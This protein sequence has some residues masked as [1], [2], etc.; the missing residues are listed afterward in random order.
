MTQPNCGVCGAE[1]PPP[2]PGFSGRRRVTSDCKPYPAGGALAECASC[3][4]VQKPNDAA[5]RA[6][7]DAIYDAYDNYALTDGVEQSV[8]GGPNGQDYAPRSQLVLKA[9]A[10]FA[11]A[12]GQGR[13]LDY[14]CGKGPT[15]RAA[16]RL[17]PGWTIDGYDLDR[18]AQQALSQIVGFDTLFTGDPS[19][20]PNRYDL[21][22][23]MHALEHIPDGHAVLRMLGQLLTPT[24]QI[25][26]QVPNRLQN[27]FDL[28]VAD[29]TL[30]FDRQSLY[31]VVTRAGLAPLALSED[32]IVKEL[33]IVAGH[34]TPLGPPA[35]VEVSATAQ[36]DW[37][38]RIA[39]QARSADRPVGIFGTSIVGTWLAAE[40]GGAP[41]FWIDEDPAKQGL[42]IDGVP[43]LAPKSAPGGATVLMAMAPR[44][45]RSVA[46]RLGHLDLSFVPFPET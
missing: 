8:R 45:A 33:S 13:M 44:V 12:P 3:G 43:V 29:H 20:I 9:W 21:I 7:C 10:A 32:W 31:G 6:D 23:L 36:T 1:L 42:K 25:V 28:V 37:L 18:R 39:R 26:V 15:T 19:A 2:I 16:A 34:G 24:G 40:I 14:G 22:I 30:H 41:D 4:A 38:D 46:E 5:W 35:A 17:L 11:D 27:P